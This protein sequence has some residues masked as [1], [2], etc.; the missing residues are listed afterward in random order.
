[1]ADTAASADVDAPEVPGTASVAPSA[2]AVLKPGACAQDGWLTYGHDERRTSA[3]GGCCDKPLRMTWT[4]AAKPHG[5]REALLSHAIADP[6]AVF[7]VGKVGQSPAAW[8]VDPGGIQQWV[9]D[10]R[11]DIHRGNWPLLALGSL[12]FHDDGLYLLDLQTGKNRFDRGLDA[13]GQSLTDGTRYYMASTWH[14]AGPPVSI[15]AF[16][17]EGN[18]LW[19]KFQ[20]GK[21]FGDVMDDVGAIALDGGSLFYAVD[22][23]FEPNCFVAALDPSNG[24]VRWQQTTF[25]FSAMSAS[26]GRIYL[27]ETT[28]RFKPR[29]LVAR[30]QNDGHV[31]WSVP[32]QGP[33]LAAP[34]IAAHLLIIETDEGVSA[35][36]S[37]TGA[38]VWT[39]PHRRRSRSA[40]GAVTTLAAAMGSGTVIATQSRQVRIIRLDTGVDVWSGEPAGLH[41]ELHSPVLVGNRVYVIAGSSVAALDPQ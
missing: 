23:K 14:V 35:F 24:D 6:E 36:E 41:A 39:S 21:V 38:K 10:S 22:Y 20:R 9:F 3:S 4:F 16:D 11:V 31:V 37:S 7:P 2:S 40:V 15:A 25:P 19:R 13:W 29:T 33:A 34:V 8:R 17:A 28:G 32:V 30:A 12:L 26:D 18:E 1:M 5:P 27:V